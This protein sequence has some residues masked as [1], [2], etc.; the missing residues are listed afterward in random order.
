MRCQSGIGVYTMRTYVY[1]RLYMPS[2]YGI[3]KEQVNIC[4]HHLLNDTL[5]FYI[6]E[7]CVCLLPYMKL[8]KI[9]GHI[10]EYGYK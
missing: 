1:I 5:S 7:P 6:P 9:A 10:T 3:G 4:L 8:D 2:D